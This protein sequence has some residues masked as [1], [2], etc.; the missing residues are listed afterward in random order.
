MD[1]WQVN[2]MMGRWQLEWRLSWV[3]VIG[4]TRSALSADP[5]T[6]MGWLGDMLLW[7]VTVAVLSVYIFY[8]VQ[9]RELQPFLSLV[10]LIRHYA[11]FPDIILVYTC[12]YR[13]NSSWKLIGK[14]PFL[15]PGMGHL[16]VC[17]MWLVLDWLFVNPGAVSSFILKTESDIAFKMK[18]PR[19]R[20]LGKKKTTALYNKVE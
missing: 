4:T 10:C 6:H 3:E 1:G 11:G 18:S 12:A 16:S 20:Q 2:R 8:G 14:H 7:S 9:V 17:V 13:P 5:L 19:A 15:L